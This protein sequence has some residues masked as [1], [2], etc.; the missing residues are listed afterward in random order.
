MLTKLIADYSFEE[1]VAIEESDRQFLALR[2]AWELIKNRDFGDVD[3]KVVQEVFLRAVIY[4]ALIS[5]QIAGSGELRWEE[6]AEKLKSDFDILLLD[7]I[8]G[9]ASFDR[10]Y[11]LMITSKYNKRLYNIKVARLKKLSQ[12]SLKSMDLYH[13]DM[14]G[15]W[16]D[17]G[18]A[19]SVPIWSKT[20]C[21][22]VKMFGYAAR[23]VYD[24][25]VPYP[26]DVAIPVDSRI[27][28]LFLISYGALSDK[29]IIAKTYELSK[30]SGI[31]SLHLDSL[32]W[33]KR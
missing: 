4:N 21:F 15:L 9:K 20:L 29:E 24:K 3:N 14:V 27:R 30:I 33:I 7:F 26:L 5:Y 31:S 1:I 18:Q 23:V 11:N 8:Q 25:F 17:L 22:A 12:F 2:S 10:W 6:F 16:Q 13:D 28:K 19:M 32:F